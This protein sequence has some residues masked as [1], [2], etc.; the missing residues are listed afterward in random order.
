MRTRSHVIEDESRVEFNKLL[1]GGWV[2]RD[3][4]K[5]YGI[6]NEIEIFDNNGNPTGKLFWLQLKATD[7]DDESVIKGMTL[8]I[9]KLTQLNN[10]DIP[11]LLARYSTKKKHF[12]I[13]WAKSIDYSLHKESQK[14]IKI[15]FSDSDYW[16]EQTAS[17]IEKYLAIV[18][19]IRKGHFT[20]PIRSF[21]DVDPNFTPIPS[22]LI[23]SKLRKKLASYNSFIEEVFDP[24][25][26]LC[27]IS[28]S[29]ELKINFHN[30]SGAFIKIHKEI[31]S[32]SNY[33]DLCISILIGMCVCLANLD[34]NELCNTI[35][36]K[37][38]LL[39]RLFRN[40]NI[41]LILLPSLLQG[42]YFRTSITE[43]I[44]ELENEDDDDMVQLTINIILLFHQN[45]HEQE[46]VTLIE[47]FLKSQLTKSIKINNCRKIGISHYNLA[48]HYRFRAL[49]EAAFRHYLLAKR[50]YKHYVNHDYYFKEIGGVLFE[51]GK[52]YFSSKAYK[53]ALDLGSQG[54]NTKA[55]YADSLMFQGRYKE[56]TEAFDSYLLETKDNADKNDE[57]YLKFTCLSSLL[58]SGYPSIQ[59][60][61]PVKATEQ[62]L[63]NETDD[64]E[65]IKIKCENAINLDMLCPTAWFNYGVLHYQKEQWFS[66]L[67][68]YLFCALIT[69][70]DVKSWVNAFSCS[71]NEETPSIIMYH[72][73]RVAYYYNNEIFIQSL[74]EGIKALNSDQINDILEMVDK[75]ISKD[76]YEEK[77]VRLITEDTFET[78]II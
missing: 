36:F 21:I 68:S 46:N 17:N 48:N 69:H 71:L 39:K 4:N 67:I 53:K 8:P 19:I 14:T 25:D 15:K 70:R 58:E 55:L 38:S 57:W 37:A 33:N 50:H 44:K 77:T 40:K 45:K 65:L 10:Y 56:A 51:L 75:C 6:D 60:R 30:Q 63:I 16:G 20:I 54:F 12:Y 28:I 73:I 11:V 18:S 61:E 42:N 76:F 27:C 5:D 13:R 26:A 31:E 23:L 52:Y 3:K 29:D 1:P 72:I 59:K 47:E 49:F 41:L 9:L 24:F 74:H 34:Q 2:C 35:I 62:A 66:A 43:I 78:F 32:D 22:R 7:S 64:N